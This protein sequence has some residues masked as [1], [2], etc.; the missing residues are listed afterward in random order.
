MSS[1]NKV[2]SG[3]Q[4]RIDGWWKQN[5]RRIQRHEPWSGAKKEIRFKTKPCGLRPVEI[6]VSH[7]Q[8]QG[9]AMNG[10]TEIVG[11]PLIPLRLPTKPSVSFNNADAVLDRARRAPT[12]EKDEE[13]LIS[14]ESAS[15]GMTTKRGETRATGRGGLPS[16]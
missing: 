3:V 15:I 5:H 7:L 1:E 14:R 4:D 16:L 12:G 8:R 13:S 2:W 9:T 10:P 11:P 6:P